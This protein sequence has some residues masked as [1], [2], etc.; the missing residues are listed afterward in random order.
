MNN[1]DNLPNNGNASERDRLLSELADVEAAIQRLEAQKEAPKAEAPVQQNSAAQVQNEPNNAPEVPS[2]ENAGEAREE[3]SREAG[4]PVVKASQDQTKSENGKKAKRR[5]PIWLWI[6]LALVAVVVV[7]FVL[8]MCKRQNLLAHA[9]R[10]YTVSETRLAN[11]T[12]FGKDKIVTLPY[13]SEVFMLEYGEE[14]SSVSLNQRSLRRCMAP[15]WMLLDSADFHCL[16]R[17]WGNDEAR[18]AITSS[19]CRRALLSYMKNKSK[20]E[21]WKVNVLPADAK[22]NTVFFKH[23]VHQDSKYPDMVVIFQNKYAER[24][25]VMFSFDEEGHFCQVF[26][27]EAP[28]EGLIRDVYID[29]VT[30]E[31]AVDYLSDELKLAL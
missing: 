19:H 1:T 31:Y 18:E 28:A 4:K 5:C 26:D 8:Q 27:R 11:H 13:G 9:Q 2:K 23:M 14:A 24:R 3:A 10:Y 15:T 21:A 25:C 7:L 22:L 16:D 20:R 30:N 12:I 17:V 6:V 29:T